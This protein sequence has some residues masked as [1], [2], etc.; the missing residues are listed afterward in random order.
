MSFTTCGGPPYPPISLKPKSRCTNARIELI[1]VRIITGITDARRYLRA[2]WSHHTSTSA[3][4]LS[5]RNPHKQLG[6]AHQ[7]K[8]DISRI[9]HKVTS[10]PPY[11]ILDTTPSPLDVNIQPPPIG[12][13][14][15]RSALVPSVSTDLSESPA[16]MKIVIISTYRPPLLSTTFS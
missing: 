8:G 13:S 7:I 5:P 14:Q 2:L 16:K 4:G 15:R 11:T 6:H 3:G 9:S 1:S 10:L 12:V